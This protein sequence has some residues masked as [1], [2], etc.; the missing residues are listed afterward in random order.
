MCPEIGD[1]ETEDDDQTDWEKVD[2]IATCVKCNC[3]AVMKQHFD[4]IIPSLFEAMLYCRLQMV[5]KSRQ[6]VNSQFFTYWIDLY[7]EAYLR[8]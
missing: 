5:P 4:E 6:K 7:A 2:H 3:Q 8:R 1:V